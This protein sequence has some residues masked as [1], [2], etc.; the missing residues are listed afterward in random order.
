MTSR[1]SLLLYVQSERRLLHR[2][3]EQADSV[4]LWSTCTIGYTHRSVLPRLDEANAHPLQFHRQERSGSPTFEM[5]QVIEFAPAAVFFVTYF[6]SDIYV[7]TAALMIAVTL[8]FI[9][10][11]LF[12]WRITKIMWMILVGAFISGTLTI[13]L[14]NPI[15]IKWKPTV[16][17]WIISAILLANQFL[18]RKNVLEWLVGDHIKLSEHIWKHQAL[19]L[20]VGMFLSGTANL[21]VAYTFSEAVWVSYRFASVFIWPILFAIAMAI[22]LAVLGKFKDLDPH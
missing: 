20:G 10:C 12:K 6:L 9:A 15:F 18:G 1:I 13:A 16:V 5:N 8:Q 4:R 2:L 11:W 19:I 22:Y 17:S 3:F 21:I 7:A 14:Q